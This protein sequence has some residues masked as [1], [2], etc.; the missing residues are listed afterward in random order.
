MSA[1][2]PGLELRPAWLFVPGDRPDRYAKAAERSDIAIVDFEDAVA[3]ADKD[4]ARAAL[5][6]AAADGTLDPA[7]TVVRV[8]AADTEHFAVDL[9][10]L[11][12]LPFR[13][14]MVPKA[15]DPE[16][17][18]KLAD[19]EVIALVETARGAL[20]LERIAAVD[21]VRGIMWGS[22][23][24]TTSMGG[25]SSRR[26]DGRY[27]DFARHVRNELLLAA[28]AHGKWALDSI[29]GNI[30]DLDGLA[31]EATDAAESGFDAKVSIHP[32]HIAVVRSSFAPTDDQLA[33]AQGV[34]AASVGQ[35]GAFSYEGAMIDAPIL[36]QA[37]TVEGRAK[38]AGLI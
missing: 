31:E 14:V 33:W 1:Q 23:D 10:L 15:E 17:L 4:T 19:F 37:R 22:E 20:A 28:K 9:E 16:A 29:W 27:R 24:L 11:A 12:G 2:T 25:G 32:K 26:P 5:A 8:N 21:C 30:D 3:E 13:T 18:A 38:A 6:Q 34:L 7:R 36:A 35:K